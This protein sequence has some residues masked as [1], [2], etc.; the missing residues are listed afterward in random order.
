MPSITD[1]ISTVATP[2]LASLQ[3]VL[4]TN[5]P[6]VAGDH[7]ISQ[8]HTDG[9]F[10]LPAGNYDVSGTY[11]CI[12]QASSFPASAGRVLGWNDVT[13]PTISGDEYLDRIAQVCLL[14][15]LPITGAFVITNTYDIHFP[16]QLQLWPPLIGSGSKVGLHVF[17]NFA[18]EI[19]WMCVL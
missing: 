12:V 9:A 6:F 19:F 4:D 2:P 14:H 8:F 18:V 5:G 13:F 15:Q 16:S 11:G 1:I 17:P 3:Q 10:L 7:T